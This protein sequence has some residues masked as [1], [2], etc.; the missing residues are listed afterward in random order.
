MRRDPGPGADGE[1]TAQIAADL[2]A[3]LG[4]LRALHTGDDRDPG[5][6]AVQLAILLEDA[7]G[8]VL[9]DDEIL[10]LRPGG[11]ADQVVVRSLLARA[12]SRRPGVR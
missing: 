8:V 2:A 4:Q 12:G 11:V 3:D 10:G 1:L 6:D 7:L 9:T 5:L